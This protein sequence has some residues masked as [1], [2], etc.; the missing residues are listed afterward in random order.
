MRFM[1]A[2]KSSEELRKRPAASRLI[3][4][5]LEL[6]SGNVAKKDLAALR[7]LAAHLLRHVA[8]SDVNG[9][10]CFVAEQ[11]WPGLVGRYEEGHDG[12]IG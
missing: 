10:C 11:R 12:S 9:I 6:C 2:W 5:V 4:D 3:G 8:D 7:W 1:Q